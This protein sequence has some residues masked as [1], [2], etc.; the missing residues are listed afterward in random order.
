M[1][2]NPEARGRACVEWLKG[3]AAAVGDSNRTPECWADIKE[4]AF[5]LVVADVL[6][7]LATQADERSKPLASATRDVVLL[8]AKRCR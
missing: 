3:A 8:A 6:Y 7:Y 2:S 5:P 1:K 4:H